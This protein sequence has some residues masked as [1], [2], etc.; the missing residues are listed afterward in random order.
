MPAQDHHFIKRFLSYNNA[1]LSGWG[2]V[3]LA[4]ALLG[5]G[6][7]SPG[8]HIASYLV[9]S[10]II[11]LLITAMAFSYFFKPHKVSVRRILPP[12]PS[13]GGFCAYTVV[14]KNNGKKPVRNLSV[15]ESTLPY[16]LYAE[17]NH[18]SFRNT[19]D[20]LE[21]GQEQKLTL[22]FRTPRRGIF[23]LGDLL[24]GSSF[25]SGITRKP[26]RVPAAERFSVFPKF[27]TQSR[28]QL[29]QHRLFQPGGVSESSKVGDSN[30]FLSTREF[31]YGDRLRDVHWASSARAN[32]LIIK[33]Y[34]EEYIVRVGVILDTHWSKFEKPHNFE[35][36]VSL[37]AGIA[38]AL[39]RRDCVVDLYTSDEKVP[40]VSMGRS[41]GNLEHLL[42]TLCCIE[43]DV[44][45]DLGRLFAQ[46]R[47]NIRHYSSLIVLL[48]DWDT[49]RREFVEKLKTAGA[50]VRV[51]I[52]RRKATT[53]PVEE[54]VTV[55][56]PE[57]IDQ[58]I[59]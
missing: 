59:I 26:V 23:E 46:L 5:T 31:R 17:L 36:R 34:I 33:E 14:V 42:E 37:A 15:F 11:S 16:G 54:M 41:I 30:E 51:I 48:K 13:A 21:P 49:P 44:S 40:P 52:P 19:I 27:T 2:K 50:N 43:G 22:V 56:K 8:T 20:W 39:D 28:L 32:K 53:L 1:R 4:A 3:L 57:K 18:P 29:T 38:D 24:V 45:V 25:P 55:V 10:F 47:M 9:P 58:L 7:A 6:A 12:P 35:A